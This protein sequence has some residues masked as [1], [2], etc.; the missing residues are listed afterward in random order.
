M[1]L[2]NDYWLFTRPVAHRG[3]WGNGVIENSLTAYK[4]AV[5]NGYPIEIDLFLTT[6]NEIVTFHDDTLTRMT[7]ESGNICDKTL[8]ELKALSLAGTD[9]KIPTLKEVLSLVNGKVPLLIEIKDQ[10]NDFIVD[11]TVEILKGYDG[12]FAVQSFNPFYIKR[13]KRL[14]PDFVRGILGTAKKER[15]R[16]TNFVLRRLPFNF[17]IK[18]DFISYEKTGLKFVKR[19]AAKTP[20]IAWTVT[21]E[22]ERQ[23][24]PPFVKNIIFEHFIPEK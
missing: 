10:E 8:K 1:R 23:T 20:V 6:D 12:E 9:E 2:K 16:I 5:D 3:L 19:K 15:G 22:T 18:P 17:M 24:L 21:T 13:V 4:K 7:G 14:A 11:K